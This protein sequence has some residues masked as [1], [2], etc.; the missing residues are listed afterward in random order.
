MFSLTK[1]HAP[2]SNVS[3][4]IIIK[5]EKTKHVHSR[6]VVWNCIKASAEERSTFLECLLA[7]S[8]RRPRSVDIPDCR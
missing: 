3:L 1:F 5:P 7:Y 2:V 4:A 6:P 8:A